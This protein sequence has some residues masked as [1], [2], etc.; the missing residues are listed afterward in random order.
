MDIDIDLKSDFKLERIF[1]KAIPASIVEK[2]ELKRH[3]VGAFFQA[4]P[5]DPMTGLAAIPYEEAEELGYLKID[6]LPLNLLSNFESRDE[7]LYFSRKEP[8]WK[9]LN[10]PEVVGR[11]FHVSKHFDTMQKMKPRCVLE[12]AD[13]L[14]IIRPGKMILLDK[15]LQ[16]KKLTRKELYTK[17]SPADLRKSH[18]LAYAYNVVINMNLIEADIL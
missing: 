15:Y 18:A 13:V 1:K 5:K 16:N 4:I 12:M 7:V 17:R 2:D 11:L 8:N 14:A 6:F 9:L 10:D 3:N